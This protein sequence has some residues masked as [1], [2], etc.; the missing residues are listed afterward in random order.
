MKFKTMSTPYKVTLK[1]LAIWK[2]SKSEVYG[3]AI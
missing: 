3:K 2:D 1:I